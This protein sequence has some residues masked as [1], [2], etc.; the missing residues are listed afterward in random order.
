[1]TVAFVGHRKVENYEA[2]KERLKE[3]VVAL[4][5]EGADTFLFG[6]SGYFNHLCYEAVSELKDSTLIFVVYTLEQS[7]M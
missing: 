1:M 5:G 7:M 4:I 3:T 6:S 2:T